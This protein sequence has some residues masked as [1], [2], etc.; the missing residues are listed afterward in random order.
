M[1]DLLSALAAAELAAA[2][3]PIQTA[4][5]NIANGDGSKES[6]VGQGL[7]LEGNLITILPTLQKIG[8]QNVANYLNS[9]LSAYLASVTPS[10]A[11]IPAPTGTENP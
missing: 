7:A 3:A 10:P 5:T 6:L 4:L 2:A 11:P 8:V 9:Q 1:S